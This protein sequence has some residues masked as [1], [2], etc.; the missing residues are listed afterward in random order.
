MVLNSKPRDFE[1]ARKTHFKGLALILLNGFVTVGCAGLIREPT[2]MLEINSTPPGALAELSIGRDCVTPCKLEVPRKHDIEVKFSLQG[3]D[4]LTS[5]VESRTD[6][7]GVTAEA[8]NAFLGYLVLSVP[9][10]YGLM[11]ALGGI[12][13][14]GSGGIGPGVWIVAGAAC[15]YLVVSSAR[16]RKQGMLRSLEPN[17]LLVELQPRAASSSRTK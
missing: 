15:V 16:D 9:A 13:N 14:G 6:V 2:Q 5:I 11:E 7:V 3:Y 1:R 10:V 17:P 4:Y 8:G 12:G